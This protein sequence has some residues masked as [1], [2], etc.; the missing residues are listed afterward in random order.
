MHMCH[1]CVKDGLHLA[2]ELLNQCFSSNVLKNFRKY[3]ASVS[4]LVHVWREKAAE[5]MAVWAHNFRDADID[6]QKLGRRYPLGVMGS[7][8]GSIEAAEDFL[9]VRERERMVPTLLEVLSRH[10]KAATDSKGHCPH[11]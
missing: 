6:I 1:A 9:L 5:I 7:R 2:D 8:W 10:M 4:K 11:C 3:F